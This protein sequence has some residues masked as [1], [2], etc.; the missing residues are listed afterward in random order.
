MDGQ[1]K[2]VPAEAK[3]WPRAT[4]MTDGLIDYGQARQEILSP[5]CTYK[6]ADYVKE[7]RRRA[8]VMKSVFDIDFGSWL[9][10]AING[11]G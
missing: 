10:D 4:V 3:D 7:L 6:D 8:G 9:K 1:T 2:W 11:K 5:L